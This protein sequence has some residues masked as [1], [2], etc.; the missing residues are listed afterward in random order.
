MEPD[1]KVPPADSLA[2]ARKLAMEK[3]E[4]NKDRK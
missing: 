3:P 4:A 1:V 2:T